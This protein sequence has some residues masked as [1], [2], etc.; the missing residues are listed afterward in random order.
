MLALAARPLDE[1]SATAAGNEIP[2]VEV[3][4]DRPAAAAMR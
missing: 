3:K 4:S 2:D 1:K